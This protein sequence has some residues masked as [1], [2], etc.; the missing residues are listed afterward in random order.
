MIPFRSR[1]YD[2][3]YPEPAR[4]QW[5]HKHLRAR[6]RIDGVSPQDAA[7]DVLAEI[8]LALRG[9]N[10]NPTF[11]LEYLDAHAELIP[12]LAETPHPEEG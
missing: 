3:Y 12:V 9:P 1:I 2:E 4:V 6:V 11:R 8:R 7:N 10:D 5:L